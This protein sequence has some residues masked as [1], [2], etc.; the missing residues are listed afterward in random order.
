MMTLSEL[1][2]HRDDLNN[3]NNRARVTCDESHA[4]ET[5]VLMLSALITQLDSQSI[6]FTP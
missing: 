5:A 6:S 1:I 4:L 2:E 3:L